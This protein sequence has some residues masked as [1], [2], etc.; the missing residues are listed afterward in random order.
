MDSSPFQTQREQRSGG[1]RV[2]ALA[3]VVVVVVSA[4]AYLSWP[5]VRSIA[6]SATPPR[7]AN[8]AVVDAATAERK[9]RSPGTIDDPAN[10]A[11]LFAG[12][13]TWQSEYG[14]DS[15]CNMVVWNEA[16]TVEEANWMYRHGFPARSVLAKL[17][18][19][20]DEVLRARF[21]AG[22][23]A[24]AGV[25]VDR[26]F[27]QG[28]SQEARVLAD[29]A[30]AR[31]SVYVLFRSAAHLRHSEDMAD[32]IMALATLHVAMMRGDHAAIEE[33]QVH[34]FQ[35]RDALRPG[36]VE[37]IEQ[38]SLA[39]LRALDALRRAQGLGP[40]P[41]Q[42]RPRLVETAQNPLTS[43]SSPTL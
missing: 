3:V 1:R 43:S 6:I 4:L 32:R 41:L 8:T 37:L 36:T 10:D 38:Q 28:Q 33:Y 17:Q 23:L 34:L 26:L 30:A 2:A 11:A 31:G 16:L 7:A 9:G 14:C 25:L 12:A 20:S 24:A 18:A 29:L 5:Q 19:L 22:D 27:E 15:R 40:M 13:A 39:Y 42:P 35:S 21:D